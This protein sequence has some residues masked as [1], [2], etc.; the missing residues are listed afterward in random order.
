MW[1]WCCLYSPKPCYPIYD[2]WCDISMNPF[3]C[4]CV[5]LVVWMLTTSCW[6]YWT[7]T[8]VVLLECLMILGCSSAT[9]MWLFWFVVD[10]FCSNCLCGGAVGV[11]A[12]VCMQFQFCS[13]WDTT[14]Y[15]VSTYRNTLV[16]KKTDKT[17]GTRNELT[18]IMPSMRV[19]LF[20]Y[21]ITWI[22]DLFCSN[23]KI[24]FYRTKRGGLGWGDR[25]G[26]KEK[27]RQSKEA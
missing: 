18:M 22:L 10:L 20:S 11:C 17:T 8:A 25:Q 19:E 26:K 1:W 24:W 21:S 12:V 5:L 7:Y 16:T 13:G 23:R 3:V 4:R 15:S 14:H 6:C 9:C 27:G 2:F